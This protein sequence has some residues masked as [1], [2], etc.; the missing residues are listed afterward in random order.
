MLDVEL[1]D[2]FPRLTYAEAL[3]RFGS[4][5]PDLRNPLELVEVGDLFRGVE[6]KVFARPAEDPA[7]RIAALRVPGGG[8]LTRKEIDDYTAL[9]G[10]YGAKGLAYIK[11]ND[12]AG[13]RD[14]L[15][16]PI[17]K[18]PAGRS[19]RWRARACSGRGR[20][21]DLLRRRTGTPSS[22]IR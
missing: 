2:P 17:L 18:V 19:D 8:R 16:S 6:F 13:G 5:K 10:R 12:A 4:D 14:G 20:R 21:P 15:Q 9:V 3:A 22:T 7:S 1:P 11:V